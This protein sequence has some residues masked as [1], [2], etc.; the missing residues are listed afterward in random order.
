[1]CDGARCVADACGA[2]FRLCGSGCA[3]C[4]SSLETACDGD[5]CVAASCPEGEV[6]C[7]EGCCPWAFD[8]V[9]GSGVRGGVGLALG[10]ETWVA[11]ATTSGVSIAHGAGASWS[12]EPVATG[13]WGRP[14]LA[15]GPAGEPVI[16]M[17]NTAAWSLA[18]AE[19]SGTTWTPMQYAIGLRG[20]SVGIATDPS[21]DR[22]VVYMA[23]DTMRRAWGPPWNSEMIA[24]GFDARSPVLD[25]EPGGTL[26]YGYLSGDAVGYSLRTSGWGGGGYYV[27]PVPLGVDLA[28]DTASSGD[29][30]IAVRTRAGGVLVLRWTGT[31]EVDDVGASSLAGTLDVAVGNDGTVHLVYLDSAQR[32]VYTRPSPSGWVSQVIADGTVGSGGT[33]AIEVDAAGHPHIAFAARGGGIRV[34]R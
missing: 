5:R 8:T 26:H 14:A 28:I 34:A 16:A 18:V 9:G 11:F 17:A 3:A 32:V 19:R 27:S 15:L 4:P 7:D 30:R 23:S 6:L 31:W 21:G 13:S 1:V 24:G 29:T 22:H 20:E 12:I 2:G 33:A 25:A 10:A